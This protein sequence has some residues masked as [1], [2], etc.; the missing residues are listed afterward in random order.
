MSHGDLITE[1]MLDKVNKSRNGKH[2]SNSAVA[3]IVFGKPKNSKIEDIP[4]L[5]FF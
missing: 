3:K 2:Y 1:Q 5:R 4:F